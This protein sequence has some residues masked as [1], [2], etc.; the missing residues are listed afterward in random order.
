MLRVFEG[1]QKRTQSFLVQ[2][3]TEL[4][5][6]LF[7][8]KFL[9]FRGVQVCLLSLQLDDNIALIIMNLT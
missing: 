8:R 9:S 2:T 3:M 4:E 6:V 1:S 7:G 5:E